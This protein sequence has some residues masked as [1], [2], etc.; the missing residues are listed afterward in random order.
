MTVETLPPQTQP[1]PP[2][3][4]PGPAGTR[5]VAGGHH[6]GDPAHE[7]HGHGASHDRPQL[8]GRAPRTAHVGPSM[9]RLSLAARL[10]LAALLLLPLWVA[11]ILVTG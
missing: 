10:G 11:V 8:R 7:D 3:V 5:G 6:H 1:F 2:S 4:P 9:L